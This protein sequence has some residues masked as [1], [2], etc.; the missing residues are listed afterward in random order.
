LK[1]KDKELCNNHESGKTFL[2]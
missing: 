2:D 1:V